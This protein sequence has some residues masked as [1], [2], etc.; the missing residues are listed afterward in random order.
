MA[1]T[2]E[3]RLARASLESRLGTALNQPTGEMRSGPSGML[4]VSEIADDP[5]RVAELDAAMAAL[6]DRYLA[7]GVMEWEYLLMTAHIR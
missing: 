7:G 3:D 1:D 4:P 6:A 5:E 2:L